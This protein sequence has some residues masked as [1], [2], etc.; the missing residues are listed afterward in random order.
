ML[1]VKFL[2]P[3]PASIQWPWGLWARNEL[4][5]TQEKGGVATGV[6]GHLMVAAGKWGGGWD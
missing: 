2:G 1:G 5:V 4:W 3:C 6:S